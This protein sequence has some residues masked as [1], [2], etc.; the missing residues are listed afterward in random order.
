VRD[1]GTSSRL[2]FGRAK[3]GE[4]LPAH[5]STGA[6]RLR[7]A[8]RPAGYFALAFGGIVGSGWIVVLGDWLQAAGPGGAVLGFIAG[9][10]V[11]T[12]VCAA[13]AELAGRMPNAGGEVLYA[14]ETFGRPVAFAIAWVLTLHLI[15]VSAFEGIALSWLLTTLFPVLAGVPL[16]EAM[17]E[18]VTSGTLIISVA[19]ALAIG[20]LNF[21]GVRAAVRFQS[22]V[23]YS[24]LTLSIG[25]MAVGF[26]FGRAENLEPL[27]ASAG[28]GGWIAGA[29]WIFAGCAMF[30]SGF[31]A[32]VH[33]IEERHAA[34]S[35]RR[36]VSAMLAGMIAAATFYC[37]IVLSA[38]SA[39]PW[40]GL[41]QEE[42]PAAAAFGALTPGGWL[43]TVV[44]AVATISLL[45]TWN[46]VMVMVSRL[47]FAQGR[48]AFL[49]NAIQAVHPRHGSPHIA[50]ICVTV[51]SCLGTALGRGAVHAI[52]NMCSMLLALKFLTM[53]LIL[54]KQRTLSSSAPV[55]TLRGGAP[56]LFTGI[57]A[58]AVMCAF[59]IY[60]PWVRAKG[61]IPLEWALSTIW[62]VLGLSFWWLGQ[63]KR[64][65]ADAALYPP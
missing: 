41:V 26:L 27:F 13:Y 19:G 65:R 58:V 6:P 7:S 55:F 49:P 56:L 42:M 14:L 43:A 48:L 37:T 61:G 53:L 23:T 35:P 64:I 20:Y 22:I 30:L 39:S 59:L 57:A 40:G 33:A 50:I 52:I 17:G 15:A 62:A 12:L 38:A 34:T 8:I 9:G 28:S 51:L 36:V 54:R 44:I 3:F 10:A 5:S 21:I 24:F 32:A 16:Y 4:F 18:T 29:V 31:Q 1:T 11:M 25:L 63:R 47:L 46:A 2:G 60:D 45:K